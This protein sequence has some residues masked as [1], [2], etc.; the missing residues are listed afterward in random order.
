M[1]TL[2]VS[3]NFT[4]AAALSTLG[5]VMTTA[6]PGFSSRPTLR[7]KL[8]G[9][10]TCSI[11]STAEARL[12]VP[13][14]SCAAKSGSFRSTFANGTSASYPRS[15]MSAARASQPRARSLTASAPLPAPRSIAKWPGRANRGRYQSEHFTPERWHHDRRGLGQGLLERPGRHIPEECHTI[16]HFQG[17]RLGFQAAAL[18]PVTDKL[19]AEGQTLGLQLL[20]RLQQHMRA[21]RGNQPAVEHKRRQGARRPIGGF[22]GAVFDAVVDGGR[23]RQTEQR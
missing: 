6:P 12:N 23:A 9:L 16:R 2:P 1:R 10:S 15:L 14:P 3:K 11:T 20:S 8:I 17:F 13:S 19:Q 22:S 18:G 7:R 5:V 21:F 4:R